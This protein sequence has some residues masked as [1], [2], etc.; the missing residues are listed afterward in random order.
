VNNQDNNEAKLI[1]KRTIFLDPILYNNN[2]SKEISEEVQYIQALLLKFDNY[3]LIDSNQHYCVLL[4][5]LKIISEQITEISFLDWISDQ[6]IEIII[7]SNFIEK[8]PK[9]N[10]FF[11]LVM[12]INIQY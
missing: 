8:L 6:S 4:F 7:D 10:F 3:E 1:Q 11:F 2:L 9:M 5:D 12:V